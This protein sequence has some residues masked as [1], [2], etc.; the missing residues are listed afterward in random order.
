MLIWPDCI[1]C[2]IKMGLLVGRE[3]LKDDGKV[4]DL[5]KEVLNLECLNG[6]ATNLTSPEIILDVWSLITEMAGDKN[7]LR[8]A[9]REQNEAILRLYPEIKKSV[10]ASVDPF[11]EAVR[12]AI[13]GN[14]I[15]ALVDGL[16]KGAD[17]MIAQFSS[18]TVDDE[19]VRA[20]RARVERAE[21]ILYFTDNCGEIVFD[22]ILIEVMKELLGTSVTV[23]VKTLPAMN[24]ATVEDARFV[25]IDTLAEILENGIEKPLAGTM[26]NAVSPRVLSLIEEADLLIFKGGG[27]YDTMTEEPSVIGKTSYLFQAKCFPY[28]ALHRVPVGSLVIVNN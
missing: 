13:I 23:V 16:E 14:S 5:M 8:G 17:D 2:T 4:M 15:D 25:G 1:P 3:V 26:L 10:F 6:S 19:G 27:N 22:R 12:F 21:R 9:K 11:L 18:Q 7:P 24:D 20:F 28:A